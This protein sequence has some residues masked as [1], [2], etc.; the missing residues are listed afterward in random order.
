MGTDHHAAP[1]S[2]TKELPPVQL[3]LPT[4]WQPPVAVG[5]KGIYITLEDGREVI[6][7]TSGIAVTCIGNGHP[8]A[9]EAVKAQIDKLDCE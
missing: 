5:G 3:L 7:A 2:D 6:D 8:V 9:Q 4:S 1:G